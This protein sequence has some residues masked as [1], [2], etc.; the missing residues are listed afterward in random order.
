MW[1][2]A[3]ASTHTI[4]TPRPVGN[5]GQF[6]LF[7]LSPS[8]W[9][10]S[11]D[12]PRCL[13]LFAVGLSS[14]LHSPMA[15]AICRP[16]TCASLLLLAS[17]HVPLR[18]GRKRFKAA[19]EPFCRYGPRKRRPRRQPCWRF[20]ALTTATAADVVCW[21][22]ACCGGCAYVRAT[23]APALVQHWR[24]CGFGGLCFSCCSRNSLCRRRP[25]PCRA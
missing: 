11:T 1:G 14:C 5:V 9:L 12:S 19:P 17:V 13:A 22:P 6:M 16:S 10:R 23:A 15:Q 7:S 8:N 21:A 2:V 3:A 20:D 18:F 25:S 24:R 4:P